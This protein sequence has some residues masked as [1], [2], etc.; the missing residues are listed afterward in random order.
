M[1]YSLFR[2]ASQHP[3]K[4]RTQTHA[5][6]HTHTHT[7]LKMSFASELDFLDP[8][9][10]ACM[11]GIPRMSG[12]AFD[13]ELPPKASNLYLSI[14]LIRPLKDHITTTP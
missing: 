11:P 13:E 5:R 10:G 7:K 2:F 14:S 12:S 1:D 3:K 8:K 4:K 6:A 9:Y